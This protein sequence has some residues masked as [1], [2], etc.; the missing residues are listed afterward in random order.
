MNPRRSIE[1]PPAAQMHWKFLTTLRNPCSRPTLLEERQCVMVFS[2]SRACAC[3]ALFDIHDADTLLPA[4]LAAAWHPLFTSSLNRWESNRVNV[5]TQACAVHSL[6]IVPEFPL[7]CE[8]EL[9]W[10]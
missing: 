6:G 10:D 2:I 4:A 1:G 5:L 8:R 7:L 3:A 9:R